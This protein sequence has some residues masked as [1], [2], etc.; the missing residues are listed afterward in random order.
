MD[1]RLAQHGD[2]SLEAAIAAHEREV[3]PRLERLW[4]YYRNE[5][6]GRAV[7]QFEGLPARLRGAR[8]PATDDRVS[9]NR[10]IVIENDIAWRVHTM[11]D[12][13]FGRPIRLVSTARDEATR[14]AVQAGGEFGVGIVVLPL[15]PELGDRSLLMPRVD[16]IRRLLA[17]GRRADLVAQRFHP[18]LIP[19]SLAIEYFDRSGHV[20]CVS[21][22]TQ[23][24]EK[25]GARQ[26]CVS[27]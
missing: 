16:S 5:G 27:C 15:A 13:M 3:R 19:S 18:L 21:P 4:R 1:D 11:V 22:R 14:R 20:L 10:E 12:F 2:G 9:S 6:R 26:R 25:Q 7:G 8:H 17:V 23:H 24:R